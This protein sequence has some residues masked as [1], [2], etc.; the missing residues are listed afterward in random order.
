MLAHMLMA[1]MSKHIGMQSRKPK[2]FS[3]TRYFKS[4]VH[5]SLLPYRCRL[6]S[7]GWSGVQ[8]VERE[9]M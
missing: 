4:L 7:V 9:E 1:Q 5:F 2:L 3:E 6:W 8:S